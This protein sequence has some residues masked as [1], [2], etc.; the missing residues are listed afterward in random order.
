[1]ESANNDVNAMQP[2]EKRLVNIEEYETGKA[3]EQ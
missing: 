3:I 2:Y 1:M